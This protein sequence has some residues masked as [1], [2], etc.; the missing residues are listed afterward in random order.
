MVIEELRLVAY[1]T[2]NKD[3]FR[4]T[5]NPYFL[6]TLSV[7]LLIRSIWYLSPPNLGDMNI[8]AIL[9]IFFVVL[10]MESKC[11]EVVIGGCQDDVA[12]AMVT[13][14]DSSKFV[15]S[16]SYDGRI[17]NIILSRLDQDGKHAWS[18]LIYPKDFPAGSGFLFGYDIATS[19]HGILICGQLYGRVL[20]IKANRS[21]E[22]IWTKTYF[23][24]YAR[25]IKINSKNEII[26]VG[27]HYKPNEHTRTGFVM[28]LDSNGK[29][30]WERQYYNGNAESFDLE[31]CMDDC[32]VVSGFV[33]V[34]AA[35]SSKRPVLLKLDQMG[36]VLWKN[37]YFNRETDS[38]PD[39][40]TIYDFNSVGCVSDSNFVTTGNLLTLG[41]KGHLP[42]TFKVD[43]ESGSVLWSRFYSFTSNNKTVGSLY[44]GDELL[45]YG[46]ATFVDTTPSQELLFSENMA[47]IS[48][49][50]D[51]K[52]NWS[53]SYGTY[54]R[55]M[56][57]DLEW[58]GN[59]LYLIGQ[60]REFYGQKVSHTNDDSYIIKADSKGN[61]TALM[62]GRNFASTTTFK[63]FRSNPDLLELDSSIV[64]FI[65][66]ELLD[67]LIG[68]V[69]DSS[70][71]DPVTVNE[72]IGHSALEVYPNPTTGVFRITCPE[73]ISRIVIYNN[74][75]Q[76][77]R[78]IY[79]AMSVVV[80]DLGELPQG[81]YHLGLSSAT[82]SFRHSI[83]KN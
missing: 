13:S 58:T 40:S 70:K 42:Y 80:V 62:S 18:Q 63:P 15:L 39:V 2:L 12:R 3:N 23:N 45:L 53:R 1:L 5:K 61:S 79:P 19:H 60:T 32:L 57:Y 33:T 11:Q 76:L 52:V 73:D 17:W 31:L 10:S 36:H 54:G 65:A 16:N 48:T 75:G 30:I 8:K 29:H 69:L 38:G 34:D 56:I 71:C 26:T 78:M 59:E 50:K 72:L 82:G 55:D 64:G 74:F 14:S 37:I 68:G 43:K 81:V 66:E 25:K 20:I 47:I 49:D 35:S 28:K 24:G 67:S 22:V 27:A 7:P 44:R 4:T 9:L 83:M 6:H 41:E 21:G 46:V 77:V 51:G